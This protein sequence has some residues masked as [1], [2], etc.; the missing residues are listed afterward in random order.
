MSDFVKVAEAGELPSGKGKV[1]VIGG[2]AIA[3]LNSDGKFYA[4]DN[5]CPHRGGSLGDGFVVGGIVTCP[6]HR[7]TY[8]VA[9]GKCTINPTAQVSCFEVKVEGNDVFVRA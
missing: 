1:V 5:T 8:E 2:R 3:L 4:L 7:W 9:T 6:L